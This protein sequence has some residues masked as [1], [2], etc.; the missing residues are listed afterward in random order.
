MK[1]LLFKIIFI[2]FTFSISALAKPP[3]QKQLPKGPQFSL[4]LG[5]ALSEN[6]RRDNQYDKSDKATII[7][8]IP[9]AT[10]QWGRFSIRGK[11]AQYTLYRNPLFTPHIMINRDGDTYYGEGL[12][13]R[14][15]SWF[16]GFGFRVWRLS[17]SIKKGIEDKSKSTVGKVAFHYGLPLGKTGIH[18]SS[19]VGL[20]F[21]NSKYTQYYYGVTNLEA[22]SKFQEYSPSSTINKFISVNLMGRVTEKVSYLVGPGYKLLGS[23][24]YNSP[25]IRKKTSFFMIAG[26]MYKF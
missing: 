22:N 20:E 9:V 25:T 3:H 6:V 18:L 7:S 14:K 17:F 13:R 8:P 11:G 19:S 12:N 24:V 4:G 26:M 10:F 2:L 1:T 16:A 5:V 15:P 23:E 21:L